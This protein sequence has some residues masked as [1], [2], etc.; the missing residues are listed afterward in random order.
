MYFNILT[1]FPEMFNGPLNESMIGRAQENDLLDIN[2]INI[3][4]YAS[5]KHQVTDDAPYGGGAGMV[6]KVEPVYKAW[7]DKCRNE[8]DS[9]PVI[10]MSPQGRKLNQEIVKDLSAQEGLTV[11]CGHYE[12]FDD[13][14]RS[15]I[16][17]DEISIGDYVLTGGELAAMVLIDAVA[18]M[19]PGVLGDENSVINDSFYNGLL[20]YPHY[21]RPRSFKGMEVPEVLLSGNHAEIDKWRQQESLKRT[22]LRRPDLMEVKTL[23]A[24]EIELLEDIKKDLKV[25]KR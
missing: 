19:I 8:K 3:R 25:K 20:D 14:I 16:V 11:I 21:T 4:D 5:G 9:S 7:E 6:M 12:G 18:R 10:L 24:E 22:L 13:R 23:T 17:T 15:S 2:I 1:L